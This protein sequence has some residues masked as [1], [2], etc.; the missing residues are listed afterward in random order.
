MPEAG[1]FPIRNPCPPGA[2]QCGREQLL[3]DPLSDKRILKLTREEEKRLVARIETISTY[4]ELK[5]I[6][7][8]MDQLLGLELRIEPGA[9]EVRTTR[10]FRI[11]IT[12]SPGLCRKTRQAIPAAVRRCLENHPGLGYA[13]LDAQGLFGPDHS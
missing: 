11:Q 3:A 8:R 4:D 5:H 10:G 12:E 13:I 1:F 6:V 9:N 7:E 2:C